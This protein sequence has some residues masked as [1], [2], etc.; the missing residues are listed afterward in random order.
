MRTIAADLEKMDLSDL[1]DNV[2][3]EVENGYHVKFY[4]ECGRIWG[5]ISKHRGKHR[6]KLYTTL[7]KLPPKG[8]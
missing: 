1:F 7:Y 5:D 3:R 4:S 2:C 8:M 6:D